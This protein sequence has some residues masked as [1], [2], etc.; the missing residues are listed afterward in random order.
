MTTLSKIL[1]YF[2]CVILA[3]AGLAFAFIEGRLLF[4]GDW[5]VFQTPFIGF[6][7][8]FIRFALS[9]FAFGVGVLGIV[10]QNKYSFTFEAILLAI[11]GIFTSIFASNNVGVYLNIL[12]LLHLATTLLKY[13][14]NK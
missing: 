3:V 4:V 2:T 13:Y 12:A 8:Y 7:Q 6:L 5:L 10:F 11:L 9:I 14:F 1:Y